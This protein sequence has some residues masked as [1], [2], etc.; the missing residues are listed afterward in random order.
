MKKIWWVAG[1]LLAAGAI[2]VMAKGHAT[3]EMSS[4]QPDEWYILHPTDFSTVPQERQ[5]LNMARNAIRG[6]CSM[7]EYAAP[8]LLPALQSDPDISAIIRACPDSVP[9]E[10]KTERIRAAVAEFWRRRM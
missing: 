5:T 4:V 7:A 9:K 1:A 3:E 10:R 2:M 8:E 6:N